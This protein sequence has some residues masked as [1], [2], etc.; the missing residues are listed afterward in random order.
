MFNQIAVVVTTP[1]ADITGVRWEYYDDSRIVAPDE[2]I[3]NG[4]TITLRIETLVIGLGSVGLDVLVTCLRTGQQEWL[5]SFSAGGENVV[6]TGTLGQ[7]T[8]STNPADYTVQTFWPGLPD[9][10]DGTAGL[11]Q[12]GDV[13]WTLPQGSRAALGPNTPR[14]TTTAMPC[15]RGSTSALGSPPPR[16]PRLR[17]STP[18][19]SRRRRCGR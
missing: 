13:T 9:V 17:C 2:V 8:V 11:S 4:G 15:P 7:T 3:D 12:S 19:G 5:Q 10:V 16:A 14:P 6:T 18:R 1:S